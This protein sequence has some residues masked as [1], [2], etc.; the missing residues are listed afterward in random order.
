MY[1]DLASRTLLKDPGFVLTP[2]ETLLVWNALGAAGEAGEM[3]DL[4]K[5]AVFH[6]HGLDKER[7]KKEIGDCLW[8]LNA[9]CRDIGTTLNEVAGGNIEKL[10][11]RYP[12]GFTSEAS[13]NRDK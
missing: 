7:I 9:I 12:E 3:A 5:K 8:Y 13:I 6:R 2:Q 1:P 4:V 10:K 11:D